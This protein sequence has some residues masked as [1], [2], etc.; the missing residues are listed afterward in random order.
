MKT[1]LKNFM[2][3]KAIV[4]EQPRDVSFREI[5]LTPKRDDTVVAL[6]R[7]NAISAGTD[8]KTWDGMQH[9]EKCWYPLVPG[10]EN[11]GTILEAGSYAPGL[12]KGTRVMINE[13]RQYL[14][15]CAAWGGGTHL[16]HKDA[17]NANGAGDPFEKIPDNVTDEQAVLAYLA[18][19]ALK[20]V[21]QLA[22]RDGECV[23]VFGAGMVGTSAIQLIKIKNP[24]VRVVCIEPNEYRRSIAAHYADFV[25]PFGA[26]GLKGLREVT[27]GKL[28]DSIIECSGNPEVPGIL[29]Q[30]LKD[31]GWGDHDEPGHIHLNGDYPEKILFDHHHR[32]FVK[33]CKI[34]MSCAIKFRAKAEVLR[35]ISEGKFDTSHLPYE[36]WE[37][38][39][40]REA[41]DYVHDKQA[42]VFKVLLDWRGL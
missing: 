20:G 33:N 4:I 12:G 18:C 25:F 21:E 31:G 19:V 27:G 37:A 15:C 24:K 13:C 14:D 9:G 34:T 17:A 39:K 30:Y 1:D 32:W 35:Y 2:K 7:M 26:A 11:V 36:V 5:T 16:V 40:V 10:Y 38:G 23:A 41:F 29:H 8:M 3:T 22:L 6:T 42:D 28:A